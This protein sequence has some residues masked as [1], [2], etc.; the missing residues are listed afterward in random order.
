MH[1]FGLH[2]SRI[3]GVHANF[4]WT[5][6]LGKSPGYGVNRS[7]G[8]GV[9]RGIW[10]GEGTHRRTDVDDAA[11]CGTEILGRLLGRKHKAE[12]VQVEVFVKM[13]LGD[14]LQ[15]QKFVDT[16]VV[17][18]NVKFAECLLSLGKEAL[19]LRLF[20]YVGLH[21]NGL[22]TVACNLVDHAVG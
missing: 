16:C 10:G 12:D 13:L 11:T 7:F 20:C 22:S 18:Q 19:D 8:G 4:A 17:D 5:Q 9:D 15:R 21:S 14:A 2:H 3:D 6:L 1:A